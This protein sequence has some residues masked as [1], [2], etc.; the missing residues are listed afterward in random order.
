MLTFNPLKA[1]AKLDFTENTNGV[2]VQRSIENLRDLDS[3]SWQLVVYPLSDNDNR[4]VLRII[5]FKG[6]LRISHPTPLRI[7]SGIKF[8]DLEDVTL[9]NSQLFNDKREAAVEFLIEPML[10]EIKKPRP[11]RLSLERGFTELPVPP[12]VVSEWQTLAS[13]TKMQNDN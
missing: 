13:T 8:W 7:S 2:G 6:S 4:I 5:G 3:Q 1:E 9:D 11:L 10:K 12:Y